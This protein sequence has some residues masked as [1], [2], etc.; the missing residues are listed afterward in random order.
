MQA[1]HSLLLQAN[2]ETRSDLARRLKENW[3]YA[4]GDVIEMI[5]GDYQSIGESICYNLESL[6]PADIFAL[7]DMPLFADNVRDDDDRV[8][9]YGPVWGFPDYQIRDHVTEL[10]HTGRT[11]LILVADYG[12]EGMLFP[13]RYREKALAEKIAVRAFENCLAPDFITEE[14]PDLHGEE[15]DTMRLLVDVAR[16]VPPVMRDLFAGH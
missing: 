2:N 16:D 5:R 9:V 10:A 14:V 8:R 4:E 7:T 12:K 1:D 3:S 15:G 6:D 11:T 13:S